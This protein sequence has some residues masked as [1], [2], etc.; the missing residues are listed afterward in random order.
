MTD[1]TQ[2]RGYLGKLRDGSDGSFKKRAGKIFHTDRFFGP[3]VSIFFFL[4]EKYNMLRHWPI[5]IAVT[6]RWSFLPHLKRL[7][8]IY[9]L[10]WCLSMFKSWYKNS[11]LRFQKQAANVTLV[12]GT[13]GLKWVY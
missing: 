1:V 2:L 11:V 9:F 12:K 10:K 4:R 8:L 5:L 3:R 13:N 7:Q 6:Q